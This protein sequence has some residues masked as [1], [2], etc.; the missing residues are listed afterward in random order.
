MAKPRL[1][2]Q[3]ENFCCAFWNNV[4]IVDVWAD[5]DPFRMRKLG[6]AYRKL[7]EDYPDGVVAISMIRASTPVSTSDAR[8]EATRFLKELG[9]RMLHHT[10]VIEAEGVVGLMLRSVVRGLNALLRSNR[11]SLHDKTEDAVPALAA[12]VAS[13]LPRDSVEKELTAAIASVRALGPSPMKRAAG[14][15]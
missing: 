4:A 7:L 15:R 13:D 5:M 3:D 12:F 8:T 11:M 6:E 9:E 2:Y 1:F 14:A 10:M